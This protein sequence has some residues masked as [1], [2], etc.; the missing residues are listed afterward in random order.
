MCVRERGTDRQTDRNL[1]LMEMLVLWGARPKAGWGVAVLTGCPIPSLWPR[2]F[3]ACMRKK[4]SR[5]PPQPRVMPSGPRMAFPLALGPSLG[6][7]IQGS[8]GRV[9]VSPGLLTP[10]ARRGRTWNGKQAAGARERQR[11]R[12]SREPGLLGLANRHPGELCGWSGLDPVGQSPSPEVAICGVSLKSSQEPRAGPAPRALVR[13]LLGITGVRVR[14]AH[15]W[16]CQ[17]GSGASEHRAGK[18]GAAYLP[19]RL[20]PLRPPLCKE[21]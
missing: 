8:F 7:Q 4:D 20:Q 11:Q 14:R 21:P 16:S 3:S 5:C 12:G 17:P 13:I 10:N 1:A 15:S 6:Q 18:A 9:L 2:P 19:S